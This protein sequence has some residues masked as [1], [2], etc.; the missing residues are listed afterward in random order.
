M[1]PPASFYLDYNFILNIDLFSNDG[2]LHFLFSD[3][4]DQPSSKW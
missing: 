2:K 3:I 1:I 4:P